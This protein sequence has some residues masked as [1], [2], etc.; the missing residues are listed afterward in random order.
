[1]VSLADFLTPILSEIK[2]DADTVIGNILNRGWKEDKDIHFLCGQYRVLYKI[3]SLI[4]AEVDK[5]TGVS[6]T[7]IV[8]SNTEKAIPSVEDCIISSPEP[9]FAAPCDSA[10]GN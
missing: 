10:N 9:S 3:D 7:D 2:S 1:M 4:R 6:N 8:D 5:L